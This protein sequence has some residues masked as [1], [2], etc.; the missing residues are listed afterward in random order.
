M[1]TLGMP[2]SKEQEEAYLHA[3]NVTGH[4]LGVRA[5]LMAHTVDEAA[6]MFD[7]L[8]ARARARPFEPDVRPGL[9]RALMATMARSIRLPVIRNLPVP[10][11]RWLIG[12]DTA[13]EIGVNER[14]GLLTWLAFHATRLMVRLVDAV[15]RLALPQFSLTRMFTRVVGYHLL[16]RFLLDQTRPLGLPDELLQPVHRTV[17]GWHHDGRAPRWV[18]QLEDRLTTRGE[19][20]PG[21]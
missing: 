19:W 17:A 7:G 11:T 15:V 18:N 2:L 4:V 6:A 8:Q 3:W 14:V 9:G 16:T 10:L 1:R 5:E 13:R 20:R 12:R 21:L